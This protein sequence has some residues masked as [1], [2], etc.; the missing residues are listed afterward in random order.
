[1]YRTV[2][3][4]AL[5]L[6]D[7]GDIPSA[8]NSIIQEAEAGRLLKIRGSLDYKVTFSQHTPN[9]TQRAII[10]V[11]DFLPDY[12]WGSTLT[13]LLTWPSGANMG[14]LTSSHLPPDLV[15]PLQVPA[16]IVTTSV[17][18]S[19]LSSP[20]VQGASLISKLGHVQNLQCS[21][22]NGPSTLLSLH[23]QSPPLTLHSPAPFIPPATVPHG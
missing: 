2:E 14:S 9:R 15:R 10:N 18:A 5:P 3:L 13:P 11:T 23:T 21:G 17:V 6:L 22:L 7:M 12:S 16:A 4:Q 20:C 8:S 1:M 19:W